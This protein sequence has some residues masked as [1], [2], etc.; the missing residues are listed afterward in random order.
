MENNVHHDVY[1]ADVCTRV[2]GGG[3]AEGE[4]REKDRNGTGVGRKEWRREGRRES[5][6]ERWRGEESMGNDMRKKDGDKGGRERG[7]YDDEGKGGGGEG[8]V[9][10]RRAAKRGYARRV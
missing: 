3:N 4:E 5:Q 2:D 7:G 1:N 9:E 8:R 6:E 10:A